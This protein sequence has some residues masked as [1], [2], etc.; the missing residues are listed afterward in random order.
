MTIP[1]KNASP[2]R[3]RANG[4]GIEHPTLNQYVRPCQMPTRQLMCG[5]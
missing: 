1:P 3:P 2:K 4:L 5:L